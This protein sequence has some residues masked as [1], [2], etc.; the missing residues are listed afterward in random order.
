MVKRSIL[1][2]LLNMNNCVIW[3]RYLR[4]N[5]GV[6]N[7]IGISCVEQL[8]RPEYPRRSVSGKDLRKN[9]ICFHVNICLYILNQMISYVFIYSVYFVL[10]LFM[11]G[12]IAICF[13]LTL[14]Y[15]KLSQ[16]KMNRKAK[17]IMFVPFPPL[18]LLSTTI[19]FYNVKKTINDAKCTARRSGT[20][21]CRSIFYAQPLIQYGLFGS[22]NKR[23]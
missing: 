4:W 12:R 9:R 1:Y 15:L 22:D 16:C 23:F 21:R 20:N 17:I 18:L 5:I 13:A 7:W 19:H 10:R 3:L 6:L 11:Y 8:L 2:C 14:L